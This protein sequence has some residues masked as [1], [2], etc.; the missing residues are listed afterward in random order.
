ML[1]TVSSVSPE[2]M[3]HPV[4]ETREWGLEEAKAAIK[5]F[6]AAHHGENLDYGDIKDHFED[7]PLWTIV[8][9]CEALAEEGKIAKVD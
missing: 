4:F 3:S 5:V 6:F 1:A 8:E 9:A 7:M 2:E